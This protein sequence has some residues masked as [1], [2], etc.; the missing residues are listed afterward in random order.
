M[1][2]EKSF[3]INK[4]NIYLGDISGIHL[5][6]IHFLSNTL[7][8]LSELVSIRHEEEVRNESTNS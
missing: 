6:S 8:H 5:I 7:L 3:Y 1:D 2:S 4:S